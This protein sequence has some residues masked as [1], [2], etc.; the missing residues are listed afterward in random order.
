[1]ALH[2]L[3]YVSQAAT[4]LGYPD[5]VNILEKSER[6]NLAVGITGMLCFG[7]S[8]FLQVLE[9]NRR[10]VSQTYN[11]I[12]GD[13]RHTNAELIDFSEI[14]QRAFGSWSMKVVELGTL[15]EVRNIILKYSSTDKF[16]PISINPQQ[17]LRF[18]VDI[19]ELF[20]RGTI[21]GVKP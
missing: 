15:P 20:N 13:K 8:M 4:G 18:L 17:S 6:N 10:V 3:I 1:M 11:R 9:G 21:L 16:S 2:R 12:I 5:L 14:E 7:D 19:T